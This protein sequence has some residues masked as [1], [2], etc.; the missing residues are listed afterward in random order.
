[1]ELKQ[2]RRS[3]HSFIKTQVKGQKVGGINK[4]KKLT[5]ISGFSFPCP[6]S[7]LDTAFAKA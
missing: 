7:S 1:M 3:L 4:T 2:P 5:T 6:F